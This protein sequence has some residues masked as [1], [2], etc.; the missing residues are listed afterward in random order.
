LYLTFQALNA[1]FCG[2]GCRRGGRRRIEQKEK[3]GEK[4]EEMVYEVRG[5]E[6]YEEK[7]GDERKKM[8]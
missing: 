6:V 3:K 7:R 4:A 5:T 2:S 8:S 1:Q